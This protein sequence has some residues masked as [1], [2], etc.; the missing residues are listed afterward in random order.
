MSAPTYY[1][2]P[3]ISRTPSPPKEYLR[4]RQEMGG[5]S[6]P[7]MP[8]D[9]SYQTDPHSPTETPD[10]EV[11]R[12]K[13]KRKA[14][15]TLRVK[16]KAKNGPV[17]WDRILSDAE[18]DGETLESITVK[19]A[20]LNVN[21]NPARD[22]AIKNKVVSQK[23][24][25]R[26]QSVTR[27][28]TAGICPE[29]IVDVCGALEAQ[30][31]TQVEAEA[32]GCPTQLE[33][34]APMAAQRSTSSPVPHTTY[35]LLTPAPSSSTPTH[36]PVK[37]AAKKK[38]VKYVRPY[39]APV[40]ATPPLAFW[41]IS[42]P[43][44]E[45]GTVPENQASPATPPPQKLA[46]STATLD[47]QLQQ[48][49]QKAMEI[50]ESA[51][52]PSNS[53][54]SAAST[55]ENQND[56]QISPSPESSHATADSSPTTSVSP[57][58]QPT[59]AN[60]AEGSP[61]PVD[62]VFHIIRTGAATNPPLTDRPFKV[63]GRDFIKSGRWMW[64]QLITT[65]KDRTHFD[66]CHDEI[67]LNWVIPLPNIEM[68]R[69]QGKEMKR[70]L[71]NEIIVIRTTREGHWPEWVYERVK[72]RRRVWKRERERERQERE[73][74]EAEER[75]R[76][77]A[78]E[79]AARAGS[80]DTIDAPVEDQN[81]VLG[82]VTETEELM[83]PAVE[84][85]AQ[86]DANMLDIVGKVST[87]L[88]APSRNNEESS[89]TE[90]PQDVD[91]EEIVASKVR[92]TPVRREI[93]DTPL[94]L[95]DEAVAPEVPESQEVFDGAQSHVE[96]AP[97]TP[98]TTAAQVSFT[99]VN[100]PQGQEVDV[101][102]GTSSIP[103]THTSAVSPG[104]TAVIPLATASSAQ[105]VLSQKVPMA[106]IPVSSVPNAALPPASVQSQTSLANA[107]PTTKITP[108]PRPPPQYRGRPIPMPPA[109]NRPA[110]MPTRPSLGVVP[111]V[112]DAP[113]RNAPLPTQTAT[114]PTTTPVVPKAAIATGQRISAGATPQQLASK[115][116]P[117][118][119]ATTTT[120]GT[121]ITT[122]VI[123]SSSKPRAASAELPPA[124]AAAAQTPLAKWLAKQG[125]PTVLPKAVQKAV[126]DSN[127]NS[128]SK[129]LGRA[130]RK[131]MPAAVCRQTAS[132]EQQAAIR[133]RPGQAVMVRQAPI[134]SQQQKLIP[135]NITTS[136]SSSALSSCPSS[137]AS[138][139]SSTTS[140][141]LIKSVA[142]I[143]V[144]VP[145][146]PLTTFAQLNPLA[147]VHPP[148]SS[149]A[150]SSISPPPSSASE[151]PT[152]TESTI[153]KASPAAPTTTSATQTPHRASNYSDESD[154]DLD[155]NL[156]LHLAP[157][158]KKETRV[159]S[160]VKSKTPVAKGRLS[161]TGKLSDFG[162]PTSVPTTP[163]AARAMRTFGGIGRTTWDGEM[164]AFDFPEVVQKEEVVVDGPDS[165]HE[166]DDDMDMGLDLQRGTKR[167]RDSM[168]T[169][170]SQGTN[171][172]SKSNSFELMG[173]TSGTIGQNRMTSGYAVSP[174]SGSQMLAMKNKSKS[175]RV[176][177]DVDCE[178]DGDDEEGFLSWEGETKGNE[179]GLNGKVEDEEDLD[180][181]F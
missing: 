110:N 156:D 142:S 22:P 80:Q 7:P 165:M 135:Q 108:P 44:S 119:A 124:I 98:S 161:L 153:T 164:P 31:G 52:L 97:D 88:L 103:T 58:A 34:P 77:E 139:A 167:P 70:M 48:E 122:P 42:T 144:N 170:L 37:T 12:P 157:R 51:V 63:Y 129:K 43:I 81:E 28:S 86:E 162:S 113:I 65:I 125:G 93:W 100:K 26:R 38:T 166:D 94:R 87:P 171:G 151:V 16:Q 18:D 106:T 158:P 8:E 61:S 116:T 145:T 66:S 10:P 36:T 21:L 169:N 127:L 79:R 128:R 59:T 85:T 179:G 101:S 123:A 89:N 74:R 148:I 102:L 159:P 147:Q 134:P 53:S 115:P 45:G 117:F 132:K 20:V 163:A 30:G 6:L 82:D 4:R 178:D 40:G 175:K 41:A 118:A 90:L 96:K 19:G 160:W 141:H 69:D 109:Y 176:R 91:I 143:P 72:E 138:A 11:L 27:A 32:Q 9:E 35:A 155:L 39:H 99:P 111:P 49:Q 76:R 180:L 17:G 54:H 24:R 1:K 67:L 114:S 55:A 3:R 73:R 46:A 33:E 149:T 29:A 78:E 71:E 140:A 105:N 154:S 136:G 56:T 137:N 62:F 152:H 57:P 112:T 126:N 15:G 172:K 25:S 104:T 150:T 120:T 173:F 107:I 13:K 68:L 5:A 60:E 84:A 133:P 92:G 47:K 130:I 146:V 177:R 83:N 168:S 64:Q 23:I 2:L 75:E 50:D 174:G 181:G 95:E 121:T 14:A 131:S